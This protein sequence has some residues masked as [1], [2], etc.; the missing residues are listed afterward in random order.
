MFGHHVNKHFYLWDAVSCA[1][2]KFL[3]VATITTPSAAA[4]AGA[5]AT[6][7]NDND[8]EDRGYKSVDLVHV[9]DVIQ[10]LS[11]AQGVQYF[12]NV[13]RSGARVLITTSYN[14]FTANQDILE[15]DWYQ[16]NLRLEPFSFPEK[17]CVY[18]HPDHEPDY[19]CVYDLM[20][21]WV[22]Q[23]VAEKCS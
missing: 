1:L 15:G 5:A 13:F 3:N 9:R 23:F 16:N 22:H 20:E 2:P 18:T 6:V 7:E 12:C 11:L 17:N 21:D 10:H 4:G 8:G 14:D 19:T